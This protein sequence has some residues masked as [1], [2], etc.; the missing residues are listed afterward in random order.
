MAPAGG[1]DEASEVLYGLHAVREALRA[2][3]RPFSRILVLGHDRQFADLVRL[4][5][6][7][8]VP[9]SV[10]PRRALD[11]LVPDGKHQGVIG[12]I[13]PRR[14]AAPEEI[15]AAARARGEPAFVV[16]LDGVED[17]R[18][19]GAVLRTAEAAGVHGVLI[20]ERRS[21]GL[22]G[23]VAKAA[24]G[25][26]EHLQVGRVQN[27]SRVIEVLKAEGLW[28]YA[29]DPAAQR[30]Y[31][32]LD[33]RGPVALVLGGE[34]KGVR[35]GVREKCDECASIP[36]LGRVGSLNVSVAAG[37]IMY[38]VLRQRMSGTKIK[39]K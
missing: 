3:T 25:A 6:A 22:T 14:Y 19:L 35:P 8:R 29:L 18:N 26:L 2:G 13:A 34:G 9:V 33:L 1:S 23:T 15:L 17:P 24:A 31:T 11:R 27:V 4:A 32:S 20:P 16:I 37:V 10:S 30:S 28:V 36:M 38:E 21:V 7:A 5:R 39:E 12:L